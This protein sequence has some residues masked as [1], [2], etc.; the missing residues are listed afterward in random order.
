MNTEPDP[1]T[2][3]RPCVECGEH[4]RDMIGFGEH[5]DYPIPAVWVGCAY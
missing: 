5:R 4:K 1:A 2:D 3:T